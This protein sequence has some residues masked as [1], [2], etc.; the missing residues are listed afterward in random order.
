MTRD[1]GIR[2]QAYV[3]VGAVDHMMYSWH[4]VVIRWPYAVS[5]CLFLLSLVL[6]SPNHII[7]S[8]SN[9]IRQSITRPLVAANRAVCQRSFSVVVPRLGEGDT[10]APR[11]GGA[12]SGY[13]QDSPSHH[14]PS[15]V[16]V[17][18]AIW[19]GKPRLL[20]IVTQ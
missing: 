10:G 18:S 19:H 4:L 12:A 5:F 13:V 11:T 2:P 6:S 20:I 7:R 8:S 15:L 1:L 14:S 16:A 3:R 17:A 9:M